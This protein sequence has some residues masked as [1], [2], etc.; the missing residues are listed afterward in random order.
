[1]FNPVLR[2]GGSILNHIMPRKTYHSEVAKAVESFWQIKIKQKSD[3]GDTT[4]RGAVTGGKQ[5][6]AFAELFRSVAISCGVPDQC[7]FTHNN[8]IP[9]YFRSSKDWDFL[10]VSPHNK[11]IAVMEFKSQI[12]S[13]GNNF[14]NRTE[15]ALGSAVDLWTAFREKQFPNQQAPWVG[16]MM[17]LG[18]DKA[19][20]SP[21]KNNESHFEVR[22]EFKQASYLDRYTILGRKLITERH[23]SAVSLLWTSDAHHFGD[24]ADDLS[25]ERYINSF[26]AYLNGCK[27]DFE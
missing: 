1:M 17:L 26:V 19:S 3:S 7:I 13:Y 22:P 12:G 10:I 2:K 16:Y 24:A 15:E 5:M 14:N 21:V 6:D 20:T 23:Y 18:K 25:I 11:L 8:Y 4:N 9:G 27:D